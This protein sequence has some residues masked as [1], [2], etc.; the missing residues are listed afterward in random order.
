MAGHI[1]PAEDLSLWTRI[2]RW[3]KGHFV[4]LEEPE[5]TREKQ[6]D[7]PQGF[8]GFRWWF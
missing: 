2:W 6:A 1:P 3:V 5:V 4:S 8:V 7:P